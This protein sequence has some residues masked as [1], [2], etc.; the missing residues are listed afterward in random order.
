M[1]DRIAL[2]IRDASGA[3][4]IEVDR[5]DPDEMESMLDIILGHVMLADDK[6]KFIVT[7]ID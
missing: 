1:E 2:E 4:T 3:I 7:P 5:L 6:I